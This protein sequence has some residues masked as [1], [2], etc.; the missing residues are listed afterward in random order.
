MGQKRKPFRR[1]RESGNPV[2][3]RSHSGILCEFPSSLSDS[4]LQHIDLFENIKFGTNLFHF[5]INWLYE[6]SD[7]LLDSR[8]RG[9]DGKMEKLGWNGVKIDGGSEQLQIML[10][11]VIVRSPIFHPL[12]RKEMPL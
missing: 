5:K 11:S 10:K 2:F 6:E 7:R 3:H 9:N 8:F 12:D 1:S 4:W